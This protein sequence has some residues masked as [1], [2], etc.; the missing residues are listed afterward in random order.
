MDTPIRMHGTQ[1][2]PRRQQ[3]EPNFDVHGYSTS[4]LRLCRGQGFQFTSSLEPR[5]GDWVLG[6]DIPGDLALMTDP[7]R[8]LRDGEVVVPTLSRLVNMLRAQAHA[9]VIDCYPTDFACMAFDENSFSLANV[10]SR[11]PEE[12][13]LR[14][15]LFIL[16]ERAANDAM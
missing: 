13:A 4:Y 14:A 2:R 8:P 15:L 10:V 1:P 6:E 12:A 16:A 9:V 5:P 7:P 3:D 11:N